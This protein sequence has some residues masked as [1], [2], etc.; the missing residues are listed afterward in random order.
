MF[1]VRISDVN[2]SLNSEQFCLD[3]ERSQ[4]Y[5]VVN[6]VLVDSL[7]A[8]SHEA[9]GLFLRASCHVVQQLQQLVLGLESI[10][11]KILQMTILMLLQTVVGFLN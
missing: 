11:L 1:F 9:L 4:W 3:F 8:D 6:G 7:N 5:L 2:F 10:Q